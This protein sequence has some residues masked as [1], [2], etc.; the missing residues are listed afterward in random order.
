MSKPYRPANQKLCYI[1]IYKILGKKEDKEC[2]LE[3]LVNTE[4]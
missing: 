1:H 2:L 4:P 3:C